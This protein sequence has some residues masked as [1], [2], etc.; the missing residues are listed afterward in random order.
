MKKLVLIVAG[1][2]IGLNSNATTQIYGY[3]GHEGW[4]YIVLNSNS[5]A[6]GSAAD[7]VSITVTLPWFM[8]GVTTLDSPTVTLD[9]LFEWTPDS[10]TDMKLSF[11]G[12]LLIGL[13]GDTYK[14]NGYN[15]VVAEPHRLSISGAFLLPDNTT[16]FWSWLN[17][18]SGEWKAFDSLEAYAPYTYALPDGGATGLLLALGMGL[19]IT[20]RKIAGR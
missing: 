11:N 2:V 20:T 13:G 17:S 8:S 1:L 10:I 7:I 14:Y 6:N 19:M 4:N 12:P 16:S 18:T 15:F 9:G 3:T 5:S